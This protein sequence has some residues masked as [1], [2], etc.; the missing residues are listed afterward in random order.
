M[1]LT[2]CKALQHGNSHYKAGECECK[3]FET[4]KPRFGTVQF[5]SSVIFV[6]Q[7]TI[8]QYV[9]ST[10]LWRQNY[11]FIY[12]ILFVPKGLQTL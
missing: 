6:L 1:T 4:V 7:F 2:I 3:S 12:I 8:H 11:N 9:A 10:W 5:S